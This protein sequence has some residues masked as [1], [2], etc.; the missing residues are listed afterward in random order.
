M[1]RTMEVLDLVEKEPS[2]RA[3]PLYLYSYR[4]QSDGLYI[5]VEAVNEEAAIPLA[6]EVGEDYDRLPDWQKI[7]PG[8]DTP[9]RIFGKYDGSTIVMVDDESREFQLK[10]GRVFNAERQLVRTVKPRKGA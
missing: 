9:I 8:E 1:Y 5:C 6:R 2:G 10:D 4:R 7:R 3:Q